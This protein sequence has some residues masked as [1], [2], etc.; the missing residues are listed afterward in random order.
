LTDVVVEEYH[1]VKP[2]PVP[3]PAGAITCTFETSFE[4]AGSQIE[5][6]GTALVVPR[7]PQG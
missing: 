1:D 6:V 7:S 3:V 5:I 4:D 2:V